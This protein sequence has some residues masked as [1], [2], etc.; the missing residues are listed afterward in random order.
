MSKYFLLYKPYGYL[1]QFT[2]EA[3]Q[4]KTLGDLFSFPKDVY[5]VGRLDQDSEGLLILTDDKSLNQKLLD[6]KFQHKRSYWVQV[7]GIPGPEALAAL[8]KGVVI[9]VENRDYTTLPAE[10]KLLPTPP[11]LPE[12][13]PPIRFRQNIPTSWI[14]LTLKEGKNRQVRKMC[15]KVGFP[16]L[17]L[18]RCRIGDLEIGGMKVGEVK[19]IKLMS[20]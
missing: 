14:E 6:P 5:P 3:A 7:E 9:R 2:R 13:D 16:V 10:V 17:R 11:P 4:H 18:V 8:K 15:A 1:S 20:Y 19:E 12:R